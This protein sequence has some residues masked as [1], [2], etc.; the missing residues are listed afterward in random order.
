MKHIHED[1]SGVCL[2]VDYSIDA[3]NTI[4]FHGVFVLDSNY[5]VVGPDLGQF[6]DKLVL[7]VQQEPEIIGERFLSTLVTEIRG[8]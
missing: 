5:R 7:L 2:E 6:L 4:T 3:D 1:P 8:E